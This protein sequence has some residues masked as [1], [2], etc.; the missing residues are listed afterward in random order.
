[1]MAVVCRK[2]LVACEELLV[3][4][5]CHSEQRQTTN[6][7]VVKKERWFHPLNSGKLK[8]NFIEWFF[9]NL[10]ERELE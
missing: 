2:L 4:C 7:R 5:C 8:A 3:L 6:R 9:S 10:K 1:M